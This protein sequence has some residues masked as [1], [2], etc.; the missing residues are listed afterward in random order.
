VAGR[1]RAHGLSVDSQYFSWVDRETE[2]GPSVAS[3]IS[4]AIKYIFS[5]L[6][7]RHSTPS[8]L[9]I[10]SYVR[11]ERVNRSRLSSLSTR[12]GLGTLRGP[13]RSKVP[14]SRTRFDYIISYNFEGTTTISYS[15]HLSSLSTLR[16]HPVAIAQQYGA[17]SGQT[18]ASVAGST[19]ISLRPV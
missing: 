17:T 3:L 2:T 18:A 14:R 10:P 1:E 6:P 13:S 5:A 12:G 9:Y 16:Q 11:C 7:C 4:I 8:C 19:H 15:L